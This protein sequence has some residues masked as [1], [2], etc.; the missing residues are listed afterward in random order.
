MKKYVIIGGG[1]AGATAAAELRKRDPNSQ[2][3]I[4]SDEKYVFYKRS[5]IIKLISA[6]C[7]EEDLFI[8]GKDVFEK[9]KIN[10]QNG[11]VKRVDTKNQ[12]VIL[13][14]NSSIQ[15]DSLLIASG[16][17]PTVIPWEGANLRGISTLYSLDDAKRVADLACDSEKVVVIGGGSIA[18]KIVQNFIKIGLDISII[19]KASHLW[20]V[21]FDRKVS[22]IIENKLKDYGIHLYLKEEVEHF[23]G[24]D[25]RVSSVV[26]RSKKKIPCD[27]VIVTI[28]MRP[29]IEF[30]KDSEIIYHRGVITD[31]YMRTNISNVY[32]AGDVAETKD[33][34]YNDFILHPTWGNAKKQARIAAKNMTSNSVKYKGTIPIQKIK[35]LNY[36]AIAAG[37]THSKKT[38]DEISWISYKNETARKVVLDGDR[39]IGL[40]IL[41]SK[42]DKKKLK[43]L[44][45]KAIFKG[46]NI[47]NPANLMLEANFG[48]EQL[49]EV[50]KYY[51]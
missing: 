24:K 26:L 19:E 38:Y 17:K 10:F 30:L 47:T 27:L 48:L 25:G 31:E 32:A 45:K 28:G 2:I 3:T 37:I 21:G 46:L 9:S 50:S 12:Q 18:M 49:F 6:S 13:E 7:T 39:L 35:V 4:I 14:D 8:G 1:P 42:L 11:H 23:E 40:L 43:K 16:G 51:P 44:M 33:P 29:S 5:Q 34:L 15:F 20:P 36:L 41:G 22:R